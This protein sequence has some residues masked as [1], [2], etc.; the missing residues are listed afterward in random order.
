M[1]KT[2]T[3]LIFKFVMTLAIT[4]LTIGL[5]NRNPWTWVVAVALIGTAVNYAIG[6]L[7]VLPTMGNLAA[8][9]GNGVMAALVAYAVQFSIPAF[10]AGLMSLALFAVLVAAGEYFFHTYLLKADK[11]AP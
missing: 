1:S 11:V 2:L 5:L 9:I 6:D 4:A 8:A 3:A 7:L 10:T